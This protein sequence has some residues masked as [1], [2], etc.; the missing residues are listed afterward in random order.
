MNWCY[1]T[2]TWFITLLHT[3]YSD[4]VWVLPWSV[5]TPT[6]RE[7][8]SLGI[9]SIC[10]SLLDICFSARILTRCQTLGRSVRCEGVGQRCVL[11]SLPYCYWQFIVYCGIKSQ[12]ISWANQLILAG[13]VRFWFVFTYLV[14]SPQKWLVLPGC[15][16]KKL[17]GLQLQ[18][19][20]TSCQKYLVLLAGKCLNVSLKVS[21]GFLLRNVET[22]VKRQQLWRLQ[23]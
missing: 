20:T 22:A 16:F 23:M 10:P 14:V 12:W 15:L 2:Q 11:W 13:L 19:V 3:R 9:W 18:I 7:E 21:S 6:P 5:C 4:P 1:L 8:Q 17:P